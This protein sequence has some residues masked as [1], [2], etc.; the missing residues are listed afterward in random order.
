VLDE[1]PLRRGG[2]ENGVSGAR[3]D[4]KEGIPLRVRLA[5]AVLADA[6]RRSR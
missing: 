2:R 1:G 6:S 4:D 3:E 5:A